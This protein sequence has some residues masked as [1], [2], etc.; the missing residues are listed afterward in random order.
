MSIPTGWQC[1]LCGKIHAPWI[2]ACECKQS[3]YKPIDIPPGYVEP[4]RTDDE[5]AF[6]PWH[7]GNP[8]EW[9]GTPKVIC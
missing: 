9:D 2:P 4:S 6:A 7:H 8:R 1:P 3:I 5:G